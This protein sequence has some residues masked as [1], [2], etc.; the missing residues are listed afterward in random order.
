VDLSPLLIIIVRQHLSTAMN[1]TFTKKLATVLCACALTTGAFAQGTVVFANGPTTLISYSPTGTPQTLPASPV[2]SFY[3]GLLIS[4]SATGPF[5]F[6]GV[7]ATNTVAA[8]HLGPGTYQPVV[9]GWLTGQTMFFEVA[10]WSASLGV[11]FKSGW[12]VNNMPAPVNDPIWLPSFGFFGLSNIG[13][14][15]AGGGPVPAP[16]L[17]VFGGTG[18]S[19]FE[20]F[21]GALGPPPP[22]PEP[23]SLTLLGLGALLI[24]RR[25]K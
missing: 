9:N 23:S 25:R 20:L 14:G 19:G 18:V 16:A 22:F 7:Y 15:A 8:G 5:T 13:S 6:T 21:P 24:F 17:P 12:L 11:T 3:F 4:S 2:G 1:S 10:G